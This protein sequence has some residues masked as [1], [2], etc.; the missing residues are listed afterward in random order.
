MTK[1]ERQRL[2]E[3]LGKLA[4]EDKEFLKN[5]I[6]R[7]SLTALYNR[8]YYN[9]NIEDIVQENKS[10]GV[11]FL[12]INKFKY[13]NDNFGHEQGDKYLK[14]LSNTIQSSI[15]AADYAIR[16]GGDEFVIL[17][18]NANKSTGPAVIKRID[19][20][21]DKYNKY[22]K[23]EKHKQGNLISCELR[24]AS[25]YA[26]GECKSPANVTKLIDI[27]DEMM[28]KEKEKEKEKACIA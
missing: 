14:G 16:W 11:V 3:I 27:A 22:N 6:E 19:S 18:L 4:G 12:D 13:L 1:T 21:L 24:V 26:F 7:D 15:K 28:Y 17:L 25:G 8:T 20:K 9:E 2:E 10:W 23:L 5:Y